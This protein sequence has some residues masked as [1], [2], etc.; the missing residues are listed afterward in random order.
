MPDTLALSPSQTLRVIDS[1]PAALVVE[2][3]WAPGPGEPPRAHLHPAQQETF[4]VLEGELTVELDGGPPQV[5]GAGETLGIPARTVHRMWNAAGEPVRASWRIAPRLG[6]EEMFRYLDAGLSPLRAVLLLWRFRREFRLARTGSGRT[7]SDTRAPE[8]PAP[9]APTAPVSATGDDLVEVTED[10]TVALLRRFLDGLDAEQRAQAVEADAI[11]REWSYLPG[12]RRGLCLESLSVE[13]RL[14]VEQVIRSGHSERGGQQVLEA[15]ARERWRRESVGG[16]PVSGDRFWIRVVGEVAGDRPWGW[17]INGHHLAVHAL[18]GPDGGMSITPHF[19]GA[20]PAVVL[21]AAGEPQAPL[22]QEERLAHDL[23]HAL[24]ESRRSVAVADVRAP[25]D[26]LTRHDPV[27]DPSVLPEGITRGNL[28]ADQRALLDRLVRRYLDRAP[29]AY[30]EAC[31]ADEVA[32][33]LDRI[34]FAWCG[35]PE[36]IGGRYYCVRGST[37]LI[38]YDNTQD[39]A[40]HAHSVWRHLRDDWGDSLRQHYVGAHPAT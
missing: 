1:T 22:G 21:N 10:P 14:L 26:I 31:W 5:L 30:A 12:D 33:G 19:V 15:I 32:A 6:T 28:D 34:R 16:G 13:Q 38:E 8:A 11:T 3:T 36:L 37:F 23:V 40:N 2:S 25:D 20:E 29:T 18:T 27:A 17:R 4:E 39:D 9:A 24:D 7:G 35:D